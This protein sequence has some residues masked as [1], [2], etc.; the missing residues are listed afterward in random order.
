MFTHGE[1]KKTQKLRMRY[2]QEKGC[3]V[4][5]EQAGTDRKRKAASETGSATPSVDGS[6]S[7]ITSQ[8]T[9]MISEQ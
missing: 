5:A 4:E 8:E 3:R 7:Y 1:G 6:T 2:T 9:G